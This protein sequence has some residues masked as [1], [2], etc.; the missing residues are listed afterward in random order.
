[1][2]SPAGSDNVRGRILP[3]QLVAHEFSAKRLKEEGGFDAYQLRQAAFDLRELK[4]GGS[5]SCIH[6]FA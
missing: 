3:D 6:T 1:M 4:E 2:A 5:L